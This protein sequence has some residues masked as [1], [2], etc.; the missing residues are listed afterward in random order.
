M[1]AAAHPAASLCPQPR[2]A[3]AHACLSSASVLL[4]LLACFAFYLKCAFVVLTQS[5]S[6][7]QLFATPWTAARQ[8]SLSLTIH[9]SLLKLMSTEWVMLFH[10]L[11]LCMSCD[12]N[13]VK[14]ISIQ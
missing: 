2:S 14:H 3:T 8:A 10:H 5:L 9:Q 13:G 1:Q 6:P 4:T 12:L 11:I 7:V